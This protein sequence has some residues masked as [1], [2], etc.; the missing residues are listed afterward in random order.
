METL[1]VIKNRRSVRRF[2]NEPI[3]KEFIEKL[4]EAAALAPSA[5]N[6]QGWH[7]ILVDDEKLKE[8]L[9]NAG[10]AITIKNS[11]TGILVLYDNRTKNLE[12]QDHIQ[13][14]AAAI[15]NLLLAATDSGLGSCWICHLPPKRRVR[16]IFK[17]PSF[18]DPIAY[19]LLG[20]PETKSQPVDRKHNLNQIISLN[21][22]Q[23]N[24]PAEKINQIG[25]AGKRIL[26]K[27]YYLMP[28]FIKKAFFNKYINKRFVKK[29]EN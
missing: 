15:Q 9:I 25:L 21:R 11:P 1:E 7:F 5:C 13:S 18:L 29:F 24:T 23:T 4:I 20:Y 6:I 14:A 28:D 26:M 12:Y 10:A 19:I 27:L 8:C 17:I 16:Q 22:Y 3:K 2:K